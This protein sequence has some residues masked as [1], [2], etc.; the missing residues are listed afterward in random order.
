MGKR[1]AAWIGIGLIAV[2]YLLTIVAAVTA[3]PDAMGLFMASIVL[4]IF[5]PIVL[6]L[7]IKMH[8]MSHQGDGISVREMRKINKRI[9]AGENPEEIAKEIEEKY[10]DKE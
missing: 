8:E 4:T 5:I 1:I 9:K 7:F 6:W 3:S 10:G 2:M